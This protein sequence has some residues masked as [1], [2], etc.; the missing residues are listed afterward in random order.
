[1]IEAKLKWSGGIRFE[2]ISGFGLPIAIDGA[3][4]SGGS[5]DGHPPVQL[6][7]FGLAGCTGVDIVIIL[8]K[9]RQQLTGVEIQVKAYQPDQY[10]KPF[11]R[12]EVKYILRGRNLDK[13]KVEQAINLSEEKYCAVT[14]SLKGVAKITST[15]EIIEE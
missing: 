15:Y 4:K 9:M 8:E 6:V 7:L 2:G 13:S 5:E 14:L 3:R 12:I 11:N 1:M 10:P